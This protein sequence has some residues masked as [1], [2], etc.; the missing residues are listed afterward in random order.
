MCLHPKEALR[1]RTRVTNDVIILVCYDENH[2]SSSTHR[3]N[4]TTTY[5][6]FDPDTDTDTDTDPDP[7]PDTADS[8]SS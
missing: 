1:T 5:Y 7:D 4:Q 8:K 6:V 2:T 3:P